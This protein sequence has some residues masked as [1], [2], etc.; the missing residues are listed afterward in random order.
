MFRGHFYVLALFFLLAGCQAKQP[1]A[2]KNTDITGS[3]L[4][5]NFS[6]KDPAGQT[7]TLNDFRGKVVIMFFGYTQCPDV[8]PTTLHDLSVVMEKLGDKAKAVQVLF[9]TVDPKRDTPQLLS[10]YVPQFNPSFLG[11]TGTDEE[12]AQVTKG[13]RIIYQR[14]EGKA[15]GTYWFNHSAGM[16]V[17][18]PK[19][20]LRL[21]IKH[22]QTPDNIVPDIQL[23]L[24]GN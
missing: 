11:L 14:V 21:L 1:V 20:Q 12:I 9:V 5:P 15:P 8:C 19:G 16:Y 7:R 24:S 2:F 6:L 23:L 4:S 17:A 13:L 3:A 18:D 22:A 10:E